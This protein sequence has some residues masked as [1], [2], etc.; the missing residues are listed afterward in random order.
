MA[1]KFNSGYESGDF[2][3]WTGEVDGGGNGAVVAE[4]AALSTD[5]GYRTTVSGTTL[6]YSNIEGLV[7]DVSQSQVSFRFR[8]WMDP[9]SMTMA[10]G[11]RTATFR[12]AI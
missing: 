9:N 6:A 10:S 3:G 12:R 2:T 1:E 4:A 5:F 8:F 7:I 11:R